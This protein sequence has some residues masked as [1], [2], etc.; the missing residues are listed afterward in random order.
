MSFLSKKTI[1][2]YASMFVSPELTVGVTAP[3]G[4]PVPQAR[5]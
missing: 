1:R 3:F 2:L 5:K 4:M